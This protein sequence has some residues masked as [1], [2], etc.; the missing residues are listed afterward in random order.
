M[1]NGDRRIVPFTEMISF[2]IN[3]VGLHSNYKVASMIVHS[4][5]PPCESTTGGQK[6]AFALR[7]IVFFYH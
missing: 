1:E 6:G 5:V 4:V 2:Q 3:W 7:S